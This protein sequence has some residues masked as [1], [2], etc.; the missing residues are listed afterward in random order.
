MASSSGA[1]TCSGPTSWAAVAVAVFSFVA[2]VVIYKVINAVMPM[3]V[4]EHDERAGLDVTQH[5]EVINSELPSARDGDGHL[6]VVKGTA[7]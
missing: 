5:G 4:S 1:S 3:R 2:T 7:A 6:S